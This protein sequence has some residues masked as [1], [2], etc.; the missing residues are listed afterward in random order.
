MPSYR[1]LL[2]EI[3][4]QSVEIDDADSPEE[5][6]RLA[7]DGEGSWGLAE[8]DHTETANIIVED[9]D[10]KTKTTV[11]IEDNGEE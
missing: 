7:F 1:V 6:A 9:L 3:H 10:Q 4:Y 5:A 2:P 11:S 8:Y